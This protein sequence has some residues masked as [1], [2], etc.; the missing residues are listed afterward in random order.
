MGFSR[1]LTPVMLPSHTSL[2]FVAVSAML[3]VVLIHL[4]SAASQ[5]LYRGPRAV[6]NTNSVREFGRRLKVMEERYD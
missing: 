5:S 2:R 1:E 4:T 3:C 6:K